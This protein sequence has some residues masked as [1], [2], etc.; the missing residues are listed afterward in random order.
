M[1]T[2]ASSPV[3][4]TTTNFINPKQICVGS[5][6]AGVVLYTVPSGK[7]FTGVLGTSAAS[8]G[9]VNITASGGVAEQINTGS[10]TAAPGALS[11]TLTSGTIVTN[12]GTNRSVL[13]G[14]ETDA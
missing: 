8:S 4:S 14:V 9:A 3:T 7:K 13:L 11:I 2:L 1:L 10:F 6:T 12:L 5:G